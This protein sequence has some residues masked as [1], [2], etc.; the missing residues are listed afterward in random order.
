MVST[1]SVPGTM[2]EHIME[3]NDS[4]CLYKRYRLPYSVV[5]GKIYTEQEIE[6]ARLSPNFS[7]EYDLQYGYGLGNLVLENNLNQCVID[8]AQ[9]STMELS[10]TVINVGVD[11]GFS[12]SKLAHAA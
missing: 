10:N 6:K 8:Y 1:P 3:E 12:T 9:P 7:R 11:I 2:F 5:V 4:T